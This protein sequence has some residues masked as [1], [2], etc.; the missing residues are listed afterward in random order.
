MGEHTHAADGTGTLAAVVEFPPPTGC[1][2]VSCTDIVLLRSPLSAV[3]TAAPSD[4]SAAQRKSGAVLLPPQCDGG[5]CASR[6]FFS[7]NRDIGGDVPP[8]W[9]PRHV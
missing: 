3:P 7:D 8:A 4:C 1:M 2:V 5:A 9:W 6:T